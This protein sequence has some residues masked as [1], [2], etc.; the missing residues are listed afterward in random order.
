MA[1][2]VVRAGRCGGRPV[3][4]QLGAAATWC[5]RP[6]ASVQLTAA[7][8]WGLD[9]PVRYSPTTAR[10]WLVVALS[11]VMVPAC[12]PAGKWKSTLVAPGGMAAMMRAPD[13]VAGSS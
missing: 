1:L 10:H 5:W 4:G 2:H 13:G 6:C 11:W 3:R 12:A 9:V 8:A 7:G